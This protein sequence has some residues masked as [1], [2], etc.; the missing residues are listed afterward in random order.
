M[1]GGVALAVLQIVVA[2]VSLL[3]RRQL[4]DDG[5]RLALNV[6][7]QKLDELSGYAKYLQGLVAS[8]PD[9]ELDRL[10]GKLTHQDGNTAAHP[11]QLVFDFQTDSSN[12]VAIQAAK[13]GSAGRAFK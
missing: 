1:W 4:L 10:Y 13:Q 11:D 6:Q 12:V 8:M 5:I 9:A 2:L 3:E 7:M